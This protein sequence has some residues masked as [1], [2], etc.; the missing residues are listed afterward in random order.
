MFKSSGEEL[1]KS[2][3]EAPMTQDVDGNVE[4]ACDVT[5]AINGEEPLETTGE[6]LLTS[7][8][9]AMLET[10]GETCEAVLSCTGGTLPEPNCALTEILPEPNGALPRVTGTDAALAWAFC[11]P[12][13]E[14]NGEKLLETNG[15]VDVLH[16]TGCGLLLDGN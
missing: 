1:P 10:N 3:G 16:G 4:A 11:E 13:P 5:C 9:G 12:L 7:T 15:V 2:N 6:A 8:G 14:T